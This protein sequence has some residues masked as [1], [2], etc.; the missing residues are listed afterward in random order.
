MKIERA[1][2]A[3]VCSEP[4][5]YVDN[6]SRKRSGHMS[7][8]MAEFAPGKIIDFNSNC[9][10]I[11]YGGHSTFGFIEYRISED[12]GETFSNVYTLPYSKQ[13]L[14]DGVH[15]ISVERAVACDDGR[16]VA[17]CLRNDAH[18]LCEPWNTPMTVTSTDGGKTWGE[19]KELCPYKGRVYDALFHDGVIYVLQMCNDGAVH[20][21]GQNEEHVYRIYTSHDRGE[22]FQELCVV[23]V[24]S[25]GRGY[26]A[27]LFDDKQRLHMY[28][29]HLHDEMH[30]EHVISED[31]GKTWSE[32]TPCYVKEGIR[33][34][35]TALMDGVYLLHGR[36][37]GCDGF[38]L[39]TSTDGQNFDEG[40][41]L[42]REKGLC[43]YSNNIVLKD[44]DGRN[45]LLVQYSEL[46]GENDCVNV[47]HLWIS[48]HKK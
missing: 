48:I 31:F 23:P 45:R 29:Y 25:L 19:P 47:K 11:L 20:F 26:G 8:A 46:Y 34:P 35:Q 38:V 43:Y 18:R 4:T 40:T 41:Y 5:V 7:H 27:L 14:Y 44:T 39:Y 6:K 10:A 21:C 13:A 3:V 32:N 37:A 2:Y 30:M 17:I 24:P 16:I 12:A 1:G 9:S 22:T 15:V 42:G 36:N 28:A 33:N